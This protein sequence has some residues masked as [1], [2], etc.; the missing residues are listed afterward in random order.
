MWYV[1]AYDIASWLYDIVRHWLWD[2]WEEDAWGDGDDSVGRGGF[3]STKG[4]AVGGLAGEARPGAGAVGETTVGP[5]WP[6]HFLDDGPSI[7]SSTMPMRSQRSRTMHRS[8][9]KALDLRRSVTSSMTWPPASRY[10]GSGPWRFTEH[11]IR[12]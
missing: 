8:I 4:T 3:L 12:L 9:S 1:G 5:A 10:V 7:L 2:S 11:M 6:A